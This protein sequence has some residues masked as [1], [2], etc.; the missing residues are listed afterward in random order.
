MKPD[1]IDKMGEILK[2]ITNDFHITNMKM[3]LLT[4]TDVTECNFVKDTADKT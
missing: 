2:V 3:M 1:I 4:A